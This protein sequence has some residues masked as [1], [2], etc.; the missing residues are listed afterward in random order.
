VAGQL[1]RRH[2]RIGNAGE[3]LVV[4]AHEFGTLAGIHDVRILEVGGGAACGNPVLLAVSLH[5]VIVHVRAHNNAEV[6]IK[7]PRG[8][9]PHEVTK[10]LELGLV[11][12][13]R[14]NE[15]Q[16]RVLTV[17][18]ALVRFEVRK[19]IEASEAKTLA[20]SFPS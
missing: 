19:P 18:I 8:R 11:R 13:Q 1:V 9:R 4:L 12:V 10:V 20:F 14:E 6:R 2:E 15:R 5:Q 3:R 16:G 7:C 17:L